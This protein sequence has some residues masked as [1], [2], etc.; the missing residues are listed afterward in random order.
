MSLSILR[1]VW[2]SVQHCSA[3]NKSWVC[4][5]HCFSTKARHYEE[6]QLCPIWKQ[7]N[8]CSLFHI[9]YIM[10][11]SHNYILVGRHHLSCLLIYIHTYHSCKCVGYPS[12]SQVPNL[13]C[14]ATLCEKE[15]SWAVCKIYN[16]VYAYKQDIYNTTLLI[17]F[18]C[19][20]CA[21]LS[22]Y[23]MK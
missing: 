8:I 2:L 9:I 21:N 22:D 19:S 5:Q 12:K 20:E 18:F 7:C 10:F 3:T 23:F 13:L 14:L 4:C 16:R 17:Y 6:N 11:K 15:L 1:I